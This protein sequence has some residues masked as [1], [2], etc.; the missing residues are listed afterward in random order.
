LGFN[1]KGSAKNKIQRFP[2]L[3]LNLKLL[4]KALS[5]AQ[6]LSVSANLIPI[7]IY[8]K[9]LHQPM[10]IVFEGRTFLLWRLKDTAGK[11]IC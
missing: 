4:I 1:E 6:V 8:S 7:K 11:K 5:K 10:T 3:K 2:L 9:D